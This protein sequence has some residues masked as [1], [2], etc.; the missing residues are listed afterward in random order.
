MQPGEDKME[1]RSAVLREGRNEKFTFTKGLAGLEECRRIQA[2]V[3][4][5]TAASVVWW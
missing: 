2:P 1:R 5:G 4:S 3:E